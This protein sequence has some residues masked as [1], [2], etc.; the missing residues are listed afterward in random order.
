MRACEGVSSSSEE[1]EDGE[2]E[3]EESSSTVPNS[4]TR[5]LDGA[6]RRQEGRL[7]SQ[8][9]LCAFTPSSASPIELSM[10]SPACTL[11]ALEEELMA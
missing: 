7:G 2:E 6:P 3:E 8:C 4:V 1:E 5:P 9:K 11:W 10:Y